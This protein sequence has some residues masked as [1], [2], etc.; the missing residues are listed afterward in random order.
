MNPY[1][2]KNHS[3]STL[4]SSVSTIDHLITTRR[5]FI[6]TLKYSVSAVTYA[7]FI[8]EVLRIS[9]KVFGLDVVD[10]LGP[11]HTCCEF[12]GF[13]DVYLWFCL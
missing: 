10:Q 7:V 11:I 13:C 3:V 4:Y 1:L 2:L 12:C 9:Y 5:Y 8:L 6:S